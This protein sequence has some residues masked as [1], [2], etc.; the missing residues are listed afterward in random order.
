MEGSCAWQDTRP[1]NG[2][3]MFY[4]NSAVCHVSLECHLLQVL[5]RNDGRVLFPPPLRIA[6]AQTGKEGMLPRSHLWVAL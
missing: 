4:K 1:G 6:G 3:P 2:T 5:V